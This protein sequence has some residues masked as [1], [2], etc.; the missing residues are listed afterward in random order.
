M[1][2]RALEAEREQHRVQMARERDEITAW[3]T[4]QVSVQVIS[5]KIFIF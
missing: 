2:E 4:A 1:I 3:V 5:A